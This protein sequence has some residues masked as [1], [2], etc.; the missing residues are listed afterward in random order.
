L[1]GAR[2]GLRAPP[3]GAGAGGRGGIASA[4]SGA[5]TSAAGALAAR[6]ARAALPDGDFAAAGLRGR[7]L[8]GAGRFAG[9][10]ATFPASDEAAV[11]AAASAE[12]PGLGGTAR[13]PLTSGTSSIPG[14]SSEEGSRG[15]GREAVTGPRYQACAAR[16]SA[17]RCM[18][19]DI[20]CYETTTDRASSAA[21]QVPSLAWKT[22]RGSV[23]SVNRW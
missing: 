3:V 15:T 8:R 17:A 11:A 1:R 22:A 2:A 23:S 7:G 13:G 5:T 21:S 12:T 16:A 14:S 9:R 4:S 20:V 6:G 10:G 18:P 19:H